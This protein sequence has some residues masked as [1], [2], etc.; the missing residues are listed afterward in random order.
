[1]TDFYENKF[2]QEEFRKMSSEE[3]IMAIAGGLV[4]PEGRPKEEMLARLLGNTEKTIETKSRKI[5]T[6]KHYLQAIAAV[7]ILLVALKVVPQFL[8]AQ[9]VRT[10]NAELQEFALPDGSQVTLNADSKIKWNKNK[11]N[12]KRFLTLKGEAF[13]DVQKGN[14]FAIK[15]QNGLVEVLGTQLNVFSRG[16][17]FWV[18]CLRGKVRVSIDNQQQIITPGELVRL[19]G[20]S[21]V[22]SKSATIENTAS[23]KNGIC[24]FEDTALKTIFEEIER[25]FDVSITFDGNN[26]RKATVDFSTKDINDALE[27]VCIPMK[28][29]YEINNNNK[30]IVSEKE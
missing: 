5:I 1:M 9:Q 23:W 4:P 8:F 22:K 28:L 24:H 25:Q 13:F 2:T 20:N 11:F 27:V 14:T 21:L 16:D 12:D 26:L 19:N 7:F 15:T 6:I 10:S 3:K 17:D 30:I 18:S 29:E